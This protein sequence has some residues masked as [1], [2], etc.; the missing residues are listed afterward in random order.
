MFQARKHHY[1]EV[2]MSREQKSPVGSSITGYAH[3]GD[4]NI[5]HNDGEEQKST[6]MDGQLRGETGG[7]TMEKKAEP[8]LEYGASPGR[9]IV[10]GC[11]SERGASLLE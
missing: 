7:R 9:D 1:F 4:E 3:P 5:L 10:K 11:V 6:S 8:F 2:E